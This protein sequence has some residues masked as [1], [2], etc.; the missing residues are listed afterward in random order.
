MYYS[1]AVWTDWVSCRIAVLVDGDGTLKFLWACPH[2]VLPD[3]PIY[4]SGT[5][6]VWSFKFVDYPTLLKFVVPVLGFQEGV[7]IVF[8]PLK[9]TCIPLL[10]HV[11]LNLSPSP[12]MY[13]TTMEM[14]LLLLLLVPLLLLLLLGWMSIELGSLLV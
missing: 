11:L 9:C 3:S 6:Y 4:P 2:H 7:F 8:V 13:G 14:F 5:V 10:L 12:C 1:E